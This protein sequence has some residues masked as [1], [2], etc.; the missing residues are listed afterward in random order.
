MA[1]ILITG[2]LGFIGSYVAK[3]L[4]EKGHNIVCFDNFIDNARRNFVGPKGQF[5][6]GDVTRIEEIISLIKQHR[7]DK[8]VALAF[9]MPGEIE[10]NLQGAV[11]VN[12]LGLNN[13]FEAARLWGIR[14]VVFASS[15]AYYGHFSNFGNRPA[16]EVPEDF[17]LAT[18][19][20]GAAKQFN[21]FMAGQ[22]NQ[23][24][25]MEII[26][27][28]P[29]VVFGP[30]RKSGTTGWIDNMIADS[31]KGLPVNIPMKSDQKVNLIYVKDLAEIFSS[32]VQADK[33]K[34]RVYNSG[35]YTVTLKEFGEM[36]KKILPDSKFI[37]N[38]QAAPFRLVYR[39]E[40]SRLREEFD[41]G[42]KSLEEN[43][44]DEIHEVESQ[45]D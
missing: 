6:R 3:R 32:I 5:Y 37:F 27:I 39:V 30:G 23:Y 38:E 35:R 24:H 25:D 36:I 2:G 41:L 43:I 10:K 13:V 11:Q 19:L 31:L 1:N 17:Y 14:R 12:I 22:Y 42:F 28:R 7:V 26:A 20:Y 21:E 18:S 16:R 8:I 15:I 44:S 45:R 29:S 4:I 9:M 40:D 33:V 34:H